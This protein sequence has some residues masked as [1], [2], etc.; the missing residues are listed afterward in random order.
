M[1]RRILLQK[2]A[3]AG[4]T[5][6]GLSVLKAFPKQVP[7]SKG[8]PLP[9]IRLGDKKVTRLIVG[10]NPI[11][12]YAYAT[13]KL[14]QHMLAYF[15]PERTAEFLV[16]C[17]S[18]GITTFQSHDSPTVRTALNMAR[19]RGSKIQWILLTSRLEHAIPK[20]LLDL[21][22]IAICHH[23]GRTDTLFLEGKP[24]VIRDFVKLVKDTGLT[25]GVSTHSPQNLAR[26]EDS[27]W[28]NDFYMTCFYN[29]DRT[30]EQVR[31]F[32]KEETVDPLHFLVADPARMTRQIRQVK[33]PCLGFKILAAGR[34][35]KDSQQVEQAFKF[36][37][38]NI[39]PSDGVIVGMYPVF[40]DEAKEDAEFA[41]K[42]GRV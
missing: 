17:E 8:E 18:Q 22:P 6:A 28:E 16:H 32:V 37:Y 30:P 33:K 1:R 10:G 21:K 42:Y 15:T 26:I 9:T 3:G 11:G 34:L 14:R 38:Q 27:A 7:A 20:E 36:A 23:G 40:S 39:K 25:A 31:Q 4:L 29:L 13:E 24:E 12:G 41:R 2:V 19:D 5:S 35:C